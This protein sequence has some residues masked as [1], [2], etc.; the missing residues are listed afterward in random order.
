[1]G[2]T[3]RLILAWVGTTALPLTGILLVVVGVDAVHRER[4]TAVTIA[5]CILGGIAGIAVAIFTGRTIIEPLRKARLAL[6]SIERGELDV[7]L[8]VSDSAELGDLELGINRMALGLRERERLRDLFGRHVGTDVAQRAMS[9][10]FALGGERCEATVMFVDIIGSTALTQ[11][12]DADAVVAILNSFFDSVVRVIAVEGGFVN[13]FQ[14][15]GALCVFGAP[16]QQHDHAVRGLRAARALADELAPN[17]EIAAAIGVSSGEVVAGN[18]GAADRYEFTVIGDAVNE[19][20]RLTEQAKLRNTH[21]LV[22]DRTIAAARAANDGWIAGETLQL[23]G[24]SE[25]TR[26]YLPR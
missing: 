20:A 25:P 10:E 2:L 15:D 17:P 6:R 9:S 3:A 24:R 19:A 18:V 5:I 23:R 21:I 4:A 7:S 11:R 13:K 22:S 14:G 12:R 8:P 26:T 16:V 1:M